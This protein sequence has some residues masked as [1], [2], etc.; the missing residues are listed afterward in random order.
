MVKKVKVFEGWLYECSE[1][2]CVDLLL[3]DEPVTM[4]TIM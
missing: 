3:F 4:D 1:Y 2:E